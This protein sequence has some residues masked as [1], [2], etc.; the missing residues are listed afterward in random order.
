[1]SEELQ[2]WA[3]NYFNYRKA[4][5]N[6]DYEVVK[7]NGVRLKHKEFSEEILCE[8]V[9]ELPSKTNNKIVI[10]TLDKKQN[11]D[12]LAKNWELFCLPG[13]RIFFV[14]PAVH[15]QKWVIT[16]AIHS[17]VCDKANIKKS[18]YSMS[19]ASRSH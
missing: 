1:M 5:L 2:E 13:L 6:E 9:L 8:E 11:I 15:G 4:C 17:K 7:D 19:D 3:C 12:F 18:L 16:P 10:V 14:T